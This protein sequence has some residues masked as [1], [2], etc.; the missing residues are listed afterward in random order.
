MHLWE[1]ANGKCVRLLKLVP[2]V[3][4]FAETFEFENEIETVE[5]LL[6]ILR[7]FLE[8]ISLRLGALYLVANELNLQITFSDK[9][10]YEHRFKIP[11]ANPQR[12][13]AVSNAAY[14]SRKF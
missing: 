6:F 1:R 2:P 4:S 9:K 8:Q 14:A 13:S 7:R 12:G 10:S 5:P 3:E 11:Q